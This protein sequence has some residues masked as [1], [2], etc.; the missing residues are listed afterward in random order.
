VAFDAGAISEWLT[1]GENGYLVPWMDTD[2]YAARL[3]KLLNDKHLARQ[4]GRRGLER[5]NKD[6]SSVRQIDKLE[7]LFLEVQDEHRLAGTRQQE[8]CTV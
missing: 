3:E 4:M 6:Y 8:E 1:D 5:V 2:L 7:S